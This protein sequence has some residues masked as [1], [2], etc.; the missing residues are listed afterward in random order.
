METDP[1]ARRLIDYNECKVRGFD[2]LCYFA[3][4]VRDY[5]DLVGLDVWDRDKN[6]GK[7]KGVLEVEL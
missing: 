4:T 7:P 1:E 3:A 5:P 6:T 2:L